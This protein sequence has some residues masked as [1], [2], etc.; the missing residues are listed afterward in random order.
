MGAIKGKSVISLSSGYSLG[1][2][3]RGTKHESREIESSE[4]LDTKLRSKKSKV[5]TKVSF[6][7]EL[8][9]PFDRSIQ[10]ARKK[11]LKKVRVDDKC[12]PSKARRVLS[13]V[14]NSEVS[15]NFLPIFLL[16]RVILESSIL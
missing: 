14:D 2:R 13:S 1:D 15:N 10:K 11:R 9:L 7:N 6:G 3:F 5:S 4:N 8:V 16:A 12:M